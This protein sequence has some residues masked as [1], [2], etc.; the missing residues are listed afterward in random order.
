VLQREKGAYHNGLLDIR[1]S[2]HGFDGHFTCDNLPG[3]KW[4]NLF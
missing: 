3:L 4:K 1:I 2:H